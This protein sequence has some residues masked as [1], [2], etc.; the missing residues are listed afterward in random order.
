[1]KGMLLVSAMIIWSVVS[2]SAQNGDEYFYQ[3]ANFY[4][5]KELNEARRSV[6]LGLQLYPDN[7]KL[8][9]LLEKMNEEQE[10]QQDQQDQEQN[11]QDNKDQQEQ[12]KDGQQDKQQEEQEQNQENQKGQSQENP[13]DQN[14]QDESGQQSTPEVGELTQEEAERLLEAMQQQEAQAHR[15]RRIR[16]VGKGYS[17]NEW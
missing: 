9:A 3:G 16:P 11:E 15:Y 10:K 5:E 17:G 2:V 4:I 8:Q 6:E 7:L 1:M 12:E 13:S 14:Q